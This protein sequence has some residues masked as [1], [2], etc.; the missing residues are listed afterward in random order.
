MMCES[1]HKNLKNQKLIQKVHNLYFMLTN[2]TFYINFYYV[3]LKIII[4]VN[5]GLKASY[6]YYAQYKSL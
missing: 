6:V 2:N 3:A 4:Y 5:L 1:N